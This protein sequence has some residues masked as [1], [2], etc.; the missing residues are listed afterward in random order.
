MLTMAAYSMAVCIDHFGKAVLY[1]VMAKKTKSL[2]P[3]EALRGAVE[4]FGGQAKLARLLGVTPPAVNQWIGGKRPVPTN[5]CH[6]ILNATGCQIQNLRPN[7]YW[8]HW[9][10]L[11]APKGEKA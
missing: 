11:K 6:A 3:N 1:Y 4:K 8:E 9:P 2:K 5:F 10:D 7:D